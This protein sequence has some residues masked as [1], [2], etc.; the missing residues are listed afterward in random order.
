MFMK[1]MIP[2]DDMKEMIP[3]FGKYSTQCLTKNWWRILLTVFYKH[4][5]NCFTV[6]NNYQN[7][8]I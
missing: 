3:T 4:V 2:Y 8:A 7:C 5:A 6:R 1:E